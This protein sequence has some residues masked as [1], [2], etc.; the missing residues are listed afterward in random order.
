MDELVNKAHHRIMD[1]RHN[2]FSHSCAQGSQVALLAPGSIDPGTN[3]VV[4][5]FTWN[6]A[7]REFPDKS[8]ALWLKTALFT[9]RERIDKDLASLI[10]EVAPKYVMDGG[11]HFLDTK[12]TDFT[13]SEE[14]N[15][16]DPINRISDEKISSVKKKN[17]ASNKL[18]PIVNYDDFKLPFVDS[19]EGMLDDFYEF[20]YTGDLSECQDQI[21]EE[22]ISL[23]PLKNKEAGDRFYTY[24]YLMPWLGMEEEDKYDWALIS[25]SFIENDFM[26]TYGLFSHARISGVKDRKQAALMMF[27]GLLKNKWSYDVK[28]RSHPP[29]HDFIKRIKRM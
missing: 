13:W 23:G 9:L 18:D 28:E 26:K 7:K 8:H 20:S 4:D 27:K 3:E 1:L 5:R 21:P 24:F 25:I 22:A 12:H 6:I 15:E 11:V 2:F 29:Y 16:S 19:E 14:S 17:P 10:S